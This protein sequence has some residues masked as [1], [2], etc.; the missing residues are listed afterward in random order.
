MPSARSTDTPLH[1]CATMNGSSRI[2]SRRTFRIT[3]DRRSRTRR[4]DAACT[5]PGTC[6]METD[7]ISRS[8]WACRRTSR[9]CGRMQGC[10]SRARP[11]ASWKPCGT[12]DPCHSTRS[13]ANWSR[14]ASRLRLRA[15]RTLSW[16]SAACR[17]ST[18]PRASVSPARA[19]RSGGRFATD[20]WSCVSSWIGRGSSAFQRRDSTA[21]RSAE[22]S[23]RRT[24]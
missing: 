22:R 1:R 11:S 15:R 23:R 3:P 6:C 8:T 20:A 19:K 4:T 16:I 5:S 2:R 12:A 24:S 18:M 13:A 21:G 7:L 10:A 9:W 14:A 17:S